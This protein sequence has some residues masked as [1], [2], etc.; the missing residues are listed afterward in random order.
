VVP[1]TVASDTAYPSLANVP[2]MP[3]TTPKEQSTAELN[4]LTA[5]RNRSE[6]GRK[7]LMSDPNATV[8]TSP[9]TGQLVDNP[10]NAVAPQVVTPPV[11]PATPQ[12]SAV[13]PVPV[14]AEPSAQSAKEEGGFNNWLHHLFPSDDQANAAPVTSAARETPPE[15]PVPVAEPAS[16]ALSVSPEVVHLTPPASP[17][18]ASQPLTVPAPPPVAA[19]ASAEI[20]PVH[21]HP[22]TSVA[23]VAGDQ[24]SDQPSLAASGDSVSLVP[25][26]ASSSQTHYLADSRY[27]ARRMQTLPADDNNNN[28]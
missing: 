1:V 23:G 10:A 3:P 16:S 21:L 6:S 11:A 26:Q 9:Q 4:A 19:D 17:G 12:A 5:D 20:E 18:P 22:P 24:S 27:A 14:P 8:M 2:P 13:L 15:N 25:P 28:D 7:Q